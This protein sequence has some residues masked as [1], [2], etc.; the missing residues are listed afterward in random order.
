MRRR[1]LLAASVVLSASAGAASASAPPKEKEGDAPVGQYVDLAPI[2]LPVLDGRRLKN[3]VFVSL[4]LNLAQ[5]ADPQKWRDKEPYFR[6]ALVRAAHRTGLNA[7]TDWSQLDENRLKA[8]MLAEAT[9]IAGAGV[10]TRVTL[11]SPQAPQRRIGR[12]R[13]PA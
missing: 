10:V 2:A 9:K 13:T 7:P 3:Y 6:D 8:L 12:P 11:N 5:R 1:D 4:R